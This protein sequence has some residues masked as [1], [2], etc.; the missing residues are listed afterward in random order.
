VGPGKRD[1]DRTL[2]VAPFGQGLRSLLLFEFLAFRVLRD[3]SADDD[4]LDDEHRQSVAG[5]VDG[6]ER[7]YPPEGV[8]PHHAD[9][10]CAQPD[11]KAYGHPAG[12]SLNT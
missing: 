3:E 11:E 9:C 8:A 6:Q 12:A 4:S 5:V 10:H 2:V 1:R 7:S